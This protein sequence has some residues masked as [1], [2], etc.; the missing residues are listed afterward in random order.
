VVITS[1]ASFNEAEAVT[2]RVRRA[3]PTSFQYRLQE[4]ELNA[5]VHA[6]ETVAYIAW[7]PSA[8]PIDGLTVE[9]KKT[10]DTVLHTFYRIVFT[11]SFSD[12]PVLLADMQTTDGGDT[13]NLRWQNKTSKGVDIKVAEE[14]SKDSEITHTKEVVGFI[15]IR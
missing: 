11:T 1:V 12:A 4:Q 7:E 5:Q 9:V 10:P 15:A 13:A 3:S 14:Q 2:G 6:K 8:G